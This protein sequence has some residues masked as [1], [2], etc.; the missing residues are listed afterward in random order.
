MFL[1]VIAV[2]LSSGCLTAQAQIQTTPVEIPDD[3]ALGMQDLAENLVLL[4]NS[5]S[6]DMDELAARFGSAADMNEAE[7]IGRAYYANNSW[8][9]GIGYY[10]AQQDKLLSTP[11]VIDFDL[12]DHTYIPNEEDFEGNEQMLYRDCVYTPDRGYVTLYYKPV[13]TPDGAYRGWF[14]FVIDVYN[15]LNLHPLFMGTP[16]SYGNFICYIVGEDGKIVYTSQV[17]NI[18]EY[19]LPSRPLSDGTSLIYAADTETGAYQYSS[20]A[21]YD[22]RQNELTEKI[23]AWT[24]ITDNRLPYT[25]YLVKELDQPEIQ[26]ENIYPDTTK[27]TIQDTRDLYVFAHEKG[28]DEAV[29]RVNHG[30]YT[31]DVV[32]MNI[33]GG[34]IASSDAKEIGENYMNARGV[35]GAAD[36]G[37][38]VLSAGQGGGFIYLTPAIDSTADPKAF[39]YNIAYVMPITDDCFIYSMFAGSPD[40]YPKDYNLTTDITLV[41]REVVHEITLDGLDAVIEKINS[42]RDAGGKLFVPDIGTDVREVAIVGFDGYVYASMQYP[43]VV[44]GSATKYIDVYGGSSTRKAILLAKTGGGF[45]RDLTKNPEKDGY[46]DLWFTAVEPVNE[47]YYVYTSAIMETVKDTLTPHIQKT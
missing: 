20:Y 3:M 29:K 42:N 38:A 36:T 28:L 31:T 37:S 46:V 12:A 47:K 4:E 17:E 27:Q 14:I 2:I 18:A 44:G 10:D 26:Y 6:K 35:Y 45:A 5:I 40:I 13:Y 7:K 19:I 33:N 25:L 30:T 22:Y 23:T 8:I 9:T 15:A 11:I 1:A 39:R 32:I 34:I 21:F 16:K 24:T 41:S 43:E